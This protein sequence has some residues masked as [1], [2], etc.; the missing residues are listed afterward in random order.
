MSE[1][2]WK[3]FFTKLFRKKS[4]SNRLNLGNLSSGVQFKIIEPTAQK[5]SLEDLVKFNVVPL[6]K[7]LDSDLRSSAPYSQGTSDKAMR[8]N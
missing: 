4:T 7:R 3:G 6:Q 8:S 2:G 5:I 1:S